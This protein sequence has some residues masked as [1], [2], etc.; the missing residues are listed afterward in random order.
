MA[1]GSLL[2]MLNVNLFTEECEVK[3]FNRAYTSLLVPG[4]KNSMV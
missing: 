3:A 1:I 2:S 4:Y